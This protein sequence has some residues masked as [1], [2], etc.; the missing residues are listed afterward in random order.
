MTEAIKNI[1]SVIDEM[2]NGGECKEG[3]YLKAMNDM[4]KMYEKEEIE[5][6]KEKQKKKKKEAREQTRLFKLAIKRVD[7]QKKCMRSDIDLYRKGQ[8]D[9]Y[10]QDMTDKYMSERNRTKDE[11]RKLLLSI[12]KIKQERYERIVVFLELTTEYFEDYCL[13][14]DQQKAF[15]KTFN[16]RAE[17]D[18]LGRDAFN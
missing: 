14:D 2:K 6:E 7:I 11:T 8:F 1:M 5:M 10:F 13:N 12:K 9:K 4:K 15:D 16:K 17:L 18:M 3:E